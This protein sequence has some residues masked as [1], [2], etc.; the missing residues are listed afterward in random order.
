MNTSAFSKPFHC[1]DGAKFIQSKKAANLIL[2]KFSVAVPN[3]KAFFSNN[4]N[5]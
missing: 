2:M 5:P 4:I 3:S 1:G